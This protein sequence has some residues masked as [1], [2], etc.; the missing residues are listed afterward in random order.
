MTRQTVARESD[1]AAAA[2]GVIARLETPDWMLA[3]PVSNLVWMARDRIV[4]NGYNP[5]R[6]APPEHRLLRTSILEN[7]W[8]APIVVHRDGE[9]EWGPLYT[10]VDGYHR[11][12]VAGDPDVAR[13]TRGMVPAVEL[14]EP[15]P[16]LARM[17][18][19]RHN[20]ARGT[21]G[22]LAMADL[23]AELRDLGVSE[24]EISRRLEM[25]PEEVERLLD[26]GVMVRRGR[27]ED[28]GEGW[29]V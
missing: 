22:V 15:D 21:H 24:A 16:A 18:T 9:D 5:N 12:L 13:L 6:Q 3:Q 23:V 8:T 26:R 1:A 2:D 17:A 28:F 29:T 27:G 20:R 25:D 4:P 11:W 14:V 19:I 10:I 7:G